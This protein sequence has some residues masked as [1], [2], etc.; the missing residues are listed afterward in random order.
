MLRIGIIGLDTSHAPAFTKILNDPRAD[1]DVSG[2]RVVAAYPHGSKHIPSSTNRIPK[3]TEQ[4]KGMGVEIVGS[5]AELLDK[6]ECVLLETNDCNPHLEQAKKVIDSGKTLFVDKPIA[7]SLNDAIAIYKYAEEK[8]VAIFSSS[9]LRYLEMAQQ[10]RH[11]KQGKVMGVSAYSPCALEKSHPDLFWYGIHG[12]EILYTV[13]GTGCK[14]VT[15]SSTKDFELVTGVWS[16]GR[17]AT[18]RGIR[19]GK[20]GYGGTAFCE[21]GIVDLGTYGGYRPLLVE[22]VKFFKTGKSPVDAAETIELY[23][24]M[25]AADVSKANGGKPVELQSLLK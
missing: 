25:A 6:V 20:S 14:T 4:L 15:R 21:K 18:F 10:V 1:A 22:I 17:I 12:V 2:C 8:G 5:I 13:M 3:Y 11:G 9:S 7:G 19:S 23:A 16:D 24:F